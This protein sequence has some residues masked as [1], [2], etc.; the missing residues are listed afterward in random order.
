MVQK[1]NFITPMDVL[2]K[3]GDKWFQA[4]LWLKF[5][6]DKEKGISVNI[7]DMNNRE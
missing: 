1:Q 7:V 6:V 4:D 5:N 3:M 2:S